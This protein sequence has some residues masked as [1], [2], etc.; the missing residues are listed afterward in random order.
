MYIRRIIIVV[1]VLFFSNV[2]VGNTDEVD[3]RDLPHKERM[4]LGGYIGLQFGNYTFV[5]ISPEIGYYITNWLSAGIGIT[6]QY[7]YERYAVP[8][9]SMHRYGG[10]SFVRFIVIPQAFI[11]AEYDI[12]NVEAIPYMQNNGGSF[13]EENY[14]LGGGYRLQLGER[15]FMNLMALYN[16]NEN[17]HVYNE[18]PVYRFSIEIGL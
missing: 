2:C 18:N 16:F 7:F 8:P 12:M 4:F 5:G 11:H 15:T 17:S 9:Y 3:V 10:K 14:F 1:L 13:W 6:Y